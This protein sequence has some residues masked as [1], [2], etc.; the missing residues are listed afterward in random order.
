[1]P[2]FFQPGM[3]TR[4][5]HGVPAQDLEWAAIDLETTGLEP[6]RDRIVE[7]AVVR[8]RGDG[9][10]TDEY[11]S[12]VNPQRRM[13]GG[14]IHQLT[15]R[16][17]TDAPLFADVWPDVVRMLS[18]AIALAHKMSF[19]D[20]FLAAE[21]A[22]LGQTA[23]AFP[24]VCSLDT[25]RAQLQGKSFKLISLHKTFT[26]EWIEDPHTALGDARALAATWSAALRHA[27]TPLYYQGPPVVPVA[28]AVAPMR[29]I[30]PRPV[31]VQSP[32]LGELARRFPR[33]SV[34]Y[35][36]DQQ[37]QQA[38]LAELRLV[39]EDE[40]ITLEESTRLEQLARRAGLTQQTLEASHRQVWDELTAALA[41][42]AQSK[43]AQQR[44]ERLATNLGLRGPARLSREQA[45]ELDA[46]ASQPHPE[47]YLRGW[48]I[49]VDS[50]P[51]TELVA[52]LA[53]R[54]GASIAKRLTNTVRWVAA[55]DPDGASATLMKARDL[56]L[57]V[58]S[59]AEAK[60]LLEQQIATAQAAE[61]DQ[62]AAQQRWQRERDEREHL[63]RH[64]WL[65]TEQLHTMEFAVARTRRLAVVHRPQIP[66]TAAAPVPIPPITTVSSVP[67]APKRSWWRRL[68]GR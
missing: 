4:A 10:I 6:S 5:V 40:V 8:F 1:M 65:A 54:H 27:P 58:I 53:S 13:G 33:C 44:R 59:V 49:G 38:Y 2:T 26:G 12:L 66:A 34:D 43:S 46:A 56:G 36:V 67:T 20:G 30:A 22:R 16:D 41:D 52:D 35:Q 7:V 24:G 45:A 15:G 60:H 55:A 28:P 29:R 42:G 3:I 37:A 64:S 17:V 25:A 39:V 32:R 19:E 50:A 68:F 14:E 48:R 57:K 47:R 9:T 61:A 11:C 18:G 62:I 63:F 21:L 31:E 23:P 51:E